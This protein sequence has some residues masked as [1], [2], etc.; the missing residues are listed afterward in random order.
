MARRKKNE[1]VNNKDF[2][3]ALVKYRDDV[4]AAEEKGRQRPRVP[5][6]VGECIMKIA[7]HLARK[8]ILLTIHLKMI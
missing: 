6:Y 5:N 8:P 3:A 4:R 2:L 1:Y 7:T